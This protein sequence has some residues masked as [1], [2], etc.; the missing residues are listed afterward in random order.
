MV[1]GGLSSGASWAIGRSDFSLNSFST[2]EIERYTA[3]L[4]SDVALS[5]RM[6]LS[7]DVWGVA[8]GPAGAA[9]YLLSRAEGTWGVSPAY[10]AGAVALVEPFRT[11]HIPILSDITVEG[12]AMHSLGQAAFYPA[13]EMKAQEMV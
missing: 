12:S 10:F 9:T 11:A 1:S 5:T 7:D 6:L 13:I 3:D 8:A 2:V 4:R